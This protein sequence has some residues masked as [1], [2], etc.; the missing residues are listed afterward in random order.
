[1]IQQFITRSLL[2][3][4]SLLHLKLEKLLY[5]KRSL[6]GRFANWKIRLQKNFHDQT[7][8]V[9]LSMHRS[10]AHQPRE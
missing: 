1:M 2:I 5:L 10:E 7:G 3:L 6:E 9:F 8:G 4:P